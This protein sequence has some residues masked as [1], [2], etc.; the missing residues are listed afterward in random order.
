MWGKYFT[1]SYKIS[2]ACLYPLKMWFYI[3]VRPNIV[4]KRH[5]NSRS[6]KCLLSISREVMVI[7]LARIIVIQYSR[8]NPKRPV[9]IAT[10]TGGRSVTASMKPP[11]P[12]SGPV[13]SIFLYTNHRSPYKARPAGAAG[14]WPRSCVSGSPRILSAFFLVINH[15]NSCC[16]LFGV[17]RFSPRC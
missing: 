7:S 13:G 4:E 9:N 2:I 6:S 5:W 16:L 11:S 8:L 10:E 12:Q 3:C 14:R 17:I 1:N 15:D